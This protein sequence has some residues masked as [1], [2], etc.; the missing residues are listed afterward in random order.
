MHAILKYLLAWLFPTRSDPRTLSR[1]E[2]F[3]FVVIVVAIGLAAGPDLFAALEMRVL[4]ELLGTA[5]F[6]TAFGA[7]AK[8]ALLQIAQLTRNMVAPVTHVAVFYGSGRCFEKGLAATYIAGNVAWVAG[9]IF[10]CAA[11][12]KVLLKNIL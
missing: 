4:L 6:M 1:K 12:V 9:M 5:L 2:A 7:G 10:V 11:W 8:L 3:W